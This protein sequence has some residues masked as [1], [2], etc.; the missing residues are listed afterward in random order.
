MKREHTAYNTLTGEVIITSNGNLLKELVRKAGYKGWRFGH[1]GF[2][3]LW[4]RISA[5][6]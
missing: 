3:S 5:V 1:K 2:E 4:A 6:K